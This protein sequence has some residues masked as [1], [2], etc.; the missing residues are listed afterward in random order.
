MALLAAPSA[1]AATTWHVDSSKNGVACTQADPCKTITE[2]V[3]KASDG[4]TI[5]VAAG[6][7]NESIST[8][9]RLTFDGA[10][11]KIFDPGSTALIGTTAGPALELTGGGNVKDM[12]VSGHDGNAPGSFYAAL[13][14]DPPGAGPAV[15]YTLTN[16]LASHGHNSGGGNAG[17]SIDAEASGRTMTVHGTNVDAVGHGDLSATVRL[18]G[19]QTT[20]TF[21][22]LRV[23]AEG[24]PAGVIA[25]VKSTLT[26]TRSSV[27][28]TF[29]ALFIGAG[30]A[31]VD[32]SELSTDR[33]PGA[34][35]TNLS[36]SLNLRD[37]LVHADPP[38]SGT[39]YG[40][41][42]GSP[43]GPATANIVGS[44]VAARGLDPQGALW[45]KSNGDDAT[46]H[47]FNS[48]FRSLPTGAT[49]PPDVYAERV[50]NQLVFTA[51]HSYYGKV[52]ATGVTLP[53]PGSGTNV[54]GDP[55]FSHPTGGDFRL[56]STSPLIDR[57][58]PAIVQAGERDATGKPRS[59]NGNG[60]CVTA[61]DIGALE[62]PGVT[63]ASCFADKTAPR[64]TKVRFKPR[65]LR[66]GQR[67]KL[68]LTLSEKAK[69]TVAVQ[70]RKGGKF[71]S[72]A[73]LVKVGV[74]PGPLK[75]KI[76]PKGTGQK[77]RP[78]RYRIR[79]RAADAAGNRSKLR[80]VTFRVARSH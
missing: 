64:I 18:S 76:G 27:S 22:R 51:S 36:G 34:V 67:G 44:T 66:V 37:S 29:D 5:A 33:A 59:L 61:P 12:I 52:T 62:V 11:D 35:I 72:F 58:D 73:K 55:G 60:D 68:S 41:Q 42:V 80:T 3:G 8:A 56:A 9:K 77:L 38:P 25:E 54:G 1:S 48:A 49:S 78:G 69:L 6:T 79:L 74:G 21:D 24:D 2:A 32:H 40:I 31:T 46:V 10:G 57:G 50:S 28:R 17:E 4:D 75:L 63:P 65:K 45:I 19:A 30:T 70:K 43:L 47:S 20:G 71:R 13:K 39:N 14:L 26:L 15:S 23:D 53:P 16:V 7:Y